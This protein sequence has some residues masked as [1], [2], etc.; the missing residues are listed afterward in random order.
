MQTMNK[1]FCGLIALAALAACTRENLVHGAGDEIVFGA[2]TGY[3]NGLETRTEYS[4]DLVG[5]SPK[6]ERINWVPNEDRIRVYCGQAT[7]RYKDQHWAD[8]QITAATNTAG[9]RNSKATL[10]P[11]VEVGTANG[12]VWGDPSDVHYFYALY[13]A[14]SMGSTA[15][16]ASISGASNNK[17]TISGSIPAEQP[18]VWNAAK[19]E[20]KPDMN[21]AYMYAVAKV[22]PQVPGEVKLGFKPLMTAVELNLVALSADPLT[23]RLTSV[24]LS[25]AESKM[26]GSF[27]ATLSEDGLEAVS[28]AEGAGNSV[29]V[30][31]GEGVTLSSQP[32]K[33]TLFAL[34]VEQKKITLT[35]GFSGGLT[36][37][38]ELRD[39][40]DWLTLTDCRKLYLNNVGVPSDIGTYHF[41]VTTPAT[42]GATGGSTGF[43]V[44][45]YRSKAGANTGI[46]WTAAFSTD[47][48][49]NWSDEL[50]SWITAC[51]VSDPDGSTAGESFTVTAAVNELVSSKVWQGTATVGTNNSKDAAIDLSTRDVY[52]NANSADKRRSAN[53]YVVSAPGWYK[54]P[55][56]YGNA[57]DEV[58]FSDGKNV[59]SYANNR[60]GANIL[61]RFLR[62]DG[63]GITD[64]WIRNN[65]ITISK[66]EILWQDGKDLLSTVSA[67][68]S[69]LYFYVAP[70]TIKQGNAL[71][72]AFQGSTVVWSWHIWV[73]DR[74]SELQTVNV[75]SHR[76]ADATR[77]NRM[78]KMNLGWLDAETYSAAPRSA[79]MRLTQNSS[80]ET[81][82]M[83]ISQE[84]RS[85][86]VSYGTGPTYQWGRKDPMLESDGS[87]SD[88]YSDKLTPR[89]E[90]Y[91]AGGA[92]LF[93]NH[94]T[95]NE[96]VSV[97][98]SI[99]HP[100]RFYRVAYRDNGPGDW[101]TEHY[102]NLWNVNGIREPGDA[103][104]N[105][106]DV[107]VVKTVYDPCPVGFT[108][109]N[110]NAFTGF[111]TTGSKNTALNQVRASN[112]ATFTSD[113]G[114]SFYVSAGTSMSGATLFFPA[115]GYQLSD[116]LGIRLVTNTGYYW[117]ATP[118]DGKGARSLQ[119]NRNG[120]DPLNS[121]FRGHAFSIRPAA[122]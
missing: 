115:N 103:T 116:G 37:R 93:V 72:G 6:Y 66:A 92:Y 13:P 87:I 85:G 91:P 71:L 50:P 46:G 67:D 14:P 56:V 12:L 3:E 98:Y 9:E 17:A 105:D 28:V 114:Y 43:Q 81:V 60:S 80:G 53:C 82:E 96:Q 20:Y 22:E 11:V 41:S 99:Q 1:L 117:T 113:Y 34:P 83:T 119:L 102:F 19:R 75:Y 4:G 15:A 2:S 16:S 70:E 86:R 62:H 36:R 10:A 122:E 84:G 59:L 97:P 27:T 51:P 89:M 44:V 73:T 26:S 94:P 108:V 39:A 30:S 74:T 23:A 101:S 78:M 120:T 45:S 32:L 104:I 48:G 29:S 112:T 110:R 33:I 47:G 77:P 106:A 121:G 42:L 100:N 79:V 57:L 61:P 38:L 111:T 95:Y 31:L 49:T 107:K 88:Q 5:T 7:H 63:N 65:G 55:A 24:T 69:Y 52:G 18:V 54:I 76:D 118:T 64:P 8:Y 90:Q 109:P 40:T 35:L 25:S 21:Y 58:K 68:A